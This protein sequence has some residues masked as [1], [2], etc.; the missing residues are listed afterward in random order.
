MYITSIQ[1]ENFRNY[2]RLNL[3]IGPSINV[4]FGENAQG[5]TN[6]IEAVY[7]CAC[8]RSHRTSKDR[9]LIFHGEDYYK[10]D[11]KLDSRRNSENEE[12]RILYE[13]SISL[14]FQEARE[15]IT[16]LIKAK[17]TA[18]HDGIPFERISDFIGIFHAVIFAPEDLLLIKEGPS[19][20]RR[21]LDLLISQ[22]LPMYFYDLQTYAK[23]LTQR[24]KTLKQLRQANGNHLLSDHEKSE[25]EIWDYPLAQVS[26]RIIAERIIFSEKIRVFSKE[27]HEQ[28]SGGKESLTVR[29]KTVTGIISDEI[30]KEPHSYLSEIEEILLRRWKASAQE[31]YEKGNTSIGPHRDDLE[32]SLDGD[33]LRAFASQGQQRSAALALKL[34]ELMILR[35][36]T[37]ES[38]VL[39]LDDVFSELDSNRRTYLLQNIEDSQVFISCTDRG[40]IEKEILET[41]E[42]DP[43]CSIA[44]RQISFYE[45]LEGT[46]EER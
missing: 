23:I 17:R 10:V 8:A 31:D 43:V 9:D 32:L 21:Y 40:F 13:E 2:R 36:Q 29:Y 25:I 1:L 6:L 5:K 33:G 42:N 26:S 14:S 18:F 45:V 11:L 34:A 27:K 30:I 20:R 28:I 7:L 19:V 22:V 16:G 38:P 37:G 41:C 35:E 4:F 46:V 44:G 15:T 12:D 24:N 3:H 39:L